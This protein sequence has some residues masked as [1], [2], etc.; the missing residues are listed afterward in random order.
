[1]S[2]YRRVKKDSHW[3]GRATLGTYLVLTFDY[4]LSHTRLSTDLSQVYR[5]NEKY[6]R[7]FVF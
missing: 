3:A 6:S 5:S 4:L 7:L 1:M 2:Y